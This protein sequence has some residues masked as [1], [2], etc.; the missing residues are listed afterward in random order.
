MLQNIS[1][2]SPM[3]YLPKH[4]KNCS[5]ISTLIIRLHNPNNSFDHHGR[6]NRIFMVHIHLLKSVRVLM[7]LNNQPYRGQI[8]RLNR[9]YFL[10]AKAHM[11]VSMAQRTV[12]ISVVFEKENE[13]SKYLNRTFCLFVCLFIR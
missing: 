10:L 9:S 6:I 3:I 4:F 1:K 12:L 5:R 2:K 8:H 13:L 7:I 11:N